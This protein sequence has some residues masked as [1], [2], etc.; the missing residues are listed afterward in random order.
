VPNA[1]DAAPAE[2]P[3]TYLL[4][5]DTGPF[6]AGVVHDCVTGLDWTYQYSGGHTADGGAQYCAELGGGWR[7]PILIELV[8]IVDFTRQDPAIDTAYFSVP[9][10]SDGN[11]LYFWT[12][13]PS[14]PGAH[15]RVH[16]ADGA[17]FQ[18][19]DTDSSY[20]VRCVRGT[21][22]AP[23]ISERYAVCGADV[24]EDVATGLHWHAG[25]GPGSW[26]VAMACDNNPG[27]RLATLKELLSLFDFSWGGVTLAS[28]PFVV[29]PPISAS[30][31]T[32][33]PVVSSCDAG[34]CS[35]V[36]Y[37]PAGGLIGPSSKMDTHRYYCVS[38]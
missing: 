26:D 36:W 13:T 7:L 6:D 28:C 29:G 18:E 22:S 19:A 23:P 35:E 2:H 21:E 3:A 34:T 30:Y 27:M 9:S 1:P 14:Q 15:Y 11:A 4:E 31:W 33:S 24:V 12:A 17:L 32:S 5:L 25:V 37:V 16:F 10:A 38:P 8:S 20:S